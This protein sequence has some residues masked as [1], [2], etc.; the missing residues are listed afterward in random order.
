MYLLSV[1]V[2]DAPSGE[3]SPCGRELVTVVL[4]GPVG[5]AAERSAGKLAP[6]RQLWLSAQELAVCNGGRMG[7]VGSGGR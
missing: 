3:K 5:N 6:K 7:P 1:P 2:A 4:W